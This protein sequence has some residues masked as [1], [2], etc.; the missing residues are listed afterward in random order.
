MEGLEG[1]EGLDSNQEP[2]PAAPQPR[3]GDPAAA[4][5]QGRSA[6]RHDATDELQKSRV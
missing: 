3:A 2:R 1:L 5:Q 4:S 6:G